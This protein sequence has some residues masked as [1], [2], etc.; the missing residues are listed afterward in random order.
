MRIGV[1]GSIATD[2][3]MTF[4]GKFGDHLLAEHL[5]KVSLSFLVD[6]L[7]VRRGGCAANIS[8]GLGVLGTVPIL[9]GAVGQDF[10]EYDTWLQK[11]GV[12]T[13]S[14]LV[15][16]TKH[17]A[18]FVCTT[19]EV[20]GQLASF[21]SGAMSDAAQI[22][23]AP[24]A[25][26]VGGLDLVLI[27]PNDPGAMIRHSEE[28]RTLGYRFVADPSQQLAWA[29]GEMIRS[30]VEG[31]DYLFT[32]EY[33]AELLTQKSGWTHDEV[34]SRVGRWVIT[35]GADGATVERAGAETIT[36]G[37][38]TPARIADPTGVGDAFRSGY[39]AGIGWGLDDTGCAQLG[40]AMAS[41]ALEVVG[42]QEYTFELSEF[43]RRLVSAY[44]DDAK[45]AVA[46]TV[47]HGPS[48]ES[49]G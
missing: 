14:V 12:D 32:N 28:C 4:P 9:I 11:H 36:V 2:H 40:S 23:L 41:L 44:G 47:A 20:G 39:L 26:R 15:S 13:G 21:Y 6:D 25:E 48:G 19:D 33:E 3:L 8:F 30:I 10:A 17:T 5:D 45:I 29:D 16:Q 18:R 42:P 34:L 49:R 35:R 43:L 22:E 37:V 1:T 24:I 27:S 31:A 7:D 38:V 46:A